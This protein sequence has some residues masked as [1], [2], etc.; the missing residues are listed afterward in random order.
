MRTVYVQHSKAMK[1]DEGV[2]LDLK[3]HGKRWLPW[4]LLSSEEEIAVEIVFVLSL[5][6]IQKEM[7]LLGT[8]SVTSKLLISQLS[9]LY[10]ES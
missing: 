7:T 3:E 4:L 2:A 8:L 10:F 5:F 1:K 6:P 9:D